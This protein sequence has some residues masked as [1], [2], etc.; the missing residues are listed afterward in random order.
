MVRADQ[1]GDLAAVLGADLGAA[2]PAG[3]VKGAH[4]AVAAA[5]HDHRIVADLQGQVLAGLLQLEGVPGENP[6]LVPDLLQI[7]AINLGIAVQRRRQGMARLA[8]ADQF[9]DLC[10]VIHVDTHS[11]T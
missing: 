5:Y 9:R 11:K 7:L 6:F 4:L 2:M 3:V 10:F 1:L 8:L